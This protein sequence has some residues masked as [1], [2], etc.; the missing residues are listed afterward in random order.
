VSNP[1][2]VIGEYKLGTMKTENQNINQVAQ[3]ELNLHLQ[4]FSASTQLM[5]MQMMMRML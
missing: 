4:I 2:Q 5:R 3:H 1:D